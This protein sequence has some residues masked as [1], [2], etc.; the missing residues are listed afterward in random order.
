M[1]FSGLETVSGY[2]L[3]K[4]WEV[5]EI[6]PGHL[7]TLEKPIVANA[8]IH[9]KEQNNKQRQFFTKQVDHYRCPQ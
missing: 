7:S 8:G 1:F 4:I 6:T 5:G 3:Q 9:Q 2:F